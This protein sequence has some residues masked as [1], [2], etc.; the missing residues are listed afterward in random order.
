MA[1]QIE[2]DFDQALRKHAERYMQD[3]D[4]TAYRLAKDANVQIQAFYRFLEEGGLNGENAYRL[5]QFLGI[6]QEELIK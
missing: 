3:N 4:I 1:Q 5:I 2:R 6:N